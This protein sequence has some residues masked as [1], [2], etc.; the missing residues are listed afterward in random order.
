NLALIH[1]SLFDLIRYR[2]PA[3]VALDFSPVT[4]RCAARGGKLYSR[5]SFRPGIT[6][7]ET[8]CTSKRHA[9]ASGPASQ[10]IC[11]SDIPSGTSTGEQ[12]TFAS[13]SGLCI[14][15]IAV[16]VGLI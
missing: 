15:I 1:N 16:M 9:C 2:L 11:K 3:T 7:D 12:A 14:C 6:A 5:L 8:K 10:T 4:T 13:V